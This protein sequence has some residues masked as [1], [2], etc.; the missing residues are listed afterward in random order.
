MGERLLSSLSGSAVEGLAV[1]LSYVSR[2]GVRC[3]AGVS[4]ASPEQAGRR[5]KRVP[6]NA[7]NPNVICARAVSGCDVSIVCVRLE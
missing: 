2:V 7:A 4:A 6:A 5:T 3:A 1:A